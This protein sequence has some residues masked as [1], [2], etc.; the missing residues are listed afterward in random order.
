MIAYVVCRVYGYTASLVKKYLG[1]YN[2]AVC[3]VKLI[4]IIYTHF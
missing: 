3:I 2:L 4:K 1:D